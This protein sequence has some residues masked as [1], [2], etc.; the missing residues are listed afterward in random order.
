MSNN[1]GVSTTPTST[2]SRGFWTISRISSTQYV[3][4]KNKTHTTIVN[5]SVAPPNLNMFGLCF[6]VDGTASAFTT[7]NQA[8]VG[9]ASGLTTAEIDT[10]VDIN[11]TYQTTLN[12]FVVV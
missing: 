9:F 10:L 2:D 4:S 5:T 11:Q 12:R 3:K 7:R 1:P 8:L 6:N